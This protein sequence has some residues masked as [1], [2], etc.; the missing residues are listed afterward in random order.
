MSRRDKGKQAKREDAPP[1]S[2]TFDII[3]DATVVHILSMVRPFPPAYAAVARTGR[4][5]AA[6]ARR[7][8]VW[9]FIDV[10]RELLDDHPARAKFLDF[11]S[12]GQDPLRRPPD[13]TMCREFTG[14]VYTW[15]DSMSLFR[16]RVNPAV[17]TFETELDIIKR[18]KNPDVIRLY[19][20]DAPKW[21]AA[22]SA[23]RRFTAQG[24]D[25]QTLHTLWI[26]AVD[27]RAPTDY[28]PL[29]IRTLRSLT[30]SGPADL[31]QALCASNPQLES[32]AVISCEPAIVQDP[33][34]SDICK[35]CPKLRILRLADYV[36]IETA[37]TP[38]AKLE[39]LTTLS[40]AR[41]LGPIYTPWIA[42]CAPNLVDVTLAL[43]LSP[44]N[45]AN[46]AALRDVSKLTK[47]E[48]VVIRL[49]LMEG[50]VLPDDYLGHLVHPGGMPKLTSVGLH[51]WNNASQIPDDVPPHVGQE[52]S[53]Y[54]HPHTVS[55]TPVLM[56]RAIRR[57]EISDTVAVCDPDVFAAAVRGGLSDITYRVDAQKVGDITSLVMRDY[58]PA[59]IRFVMGYATTHV[60]L[61]GPGPSCIAYLEIPTP[62]CIPL[63]RDDDIATV[64]RFPY[65][66]TVVM[67]RVYREYGCR[68]SQYIAA[69]FLR[70]SP[71][72]TV[73]V[74][75]SDVWIACAR[76]VPWSGRG[77]DDARMYSAAISD[78]LGVTVSA[79]L[80]NRI[81]IEYQ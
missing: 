32:L 17:P 75:A 37:P 21:P 2:P 35:W 43:P 46:I 71:R 41:P 10:G 65:M 64:R 11:L 6:I 13:L 30:F 49:S 56:G 3:D 81:T 15:Y 14:F 45:P 25:S 16:L 72:V 77:V 74:F 22:C 39:S 19:M 76:P 34:V 79:A 28:E 63:P 29:A 24:A 38:P 57:L 18:I 20:P 33:V 48:R 69:R 42:A 73:S 27:R 31:L 68:T 4:R 36:S 23:L 50:D 40:F 5:F 59:R 62:A 9:Q 44:L 8:E 80:L 58:S 61:D 66:H 53:R 47:L 54:G 51:E 1:P 60:H 12:G 55:I 70:G 78:A 52:P 7:P 67:P 26:F